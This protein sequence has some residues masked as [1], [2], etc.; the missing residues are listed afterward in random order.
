MA[1]HL[2]SSRKACEDQS[3]QSA[4]VYSVTGDSAMFLLVVGSLD[5]PPVDIIAQTQNKVLFRFDHPWLVYYQN[6]S[7]CTKQKKNKRQENR[8]GVKLPEFKYFVFVGKVGQYTVCPS[9]TF[10]QGCWLFSIS[11]YMHCSACVR[12]TSVW[13]KQTFVCAGEDGIYIPMWGKSVR[14]DSGSG[15]HRGEALSD[16]L[17]GD[18]ED[19]DRTQRGLLRPVN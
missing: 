10:I 3:Y 4:S 8:N 11:S 7:Q 9:S 6:Q 16:H 1:G 12:T 13:L 14:G 18:G 15:S 2:T 19:I 5:L 17:W